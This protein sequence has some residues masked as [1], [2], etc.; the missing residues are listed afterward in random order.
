MH[1]ESSTWTLHNKF[2]V[3]FLQLG[4]IYFLVRVT[5]LAQALTH[6]RNLSRNFLKTEIISYI[7]QNCL[8]WVTL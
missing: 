1:E 7:T 2:F 6:F 4:H 5:F 8:A 3:P